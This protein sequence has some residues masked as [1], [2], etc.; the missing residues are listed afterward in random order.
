MYANGTKLRFNNAGGGYLFESLG[1]SGVTISAV[2]GLSLPGAVVIGGNGNGLDFD[3]G[4]N[5]RISFNSNRALEGS[6]DGA[7]LQ[8]GEG[9]TKILSQGREVWYADGVYH[10]KISKTVTCTGSSVTNHEL[11]INTLLGA[12]TA[13]TL[14]YVVSIAGYGSGGSNGCNAKYSV[15]GYSAHNYSGTNYGSFGAGTIQNGYKSSNATSY[16]AQGISYHPCINMGAFIA[17][18]EVWAYSPGGQRY[19]F[20]V[21]NGSSTS[22]G[23]IITVEGVYT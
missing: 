21:S 19:G 12:G 5:Q 14:G 23:A 17:N 6:S 9:Y 18:G 3:D 11:N 22:F 1:G 8:V 7:T 10:F 4:T 20:T 13:G 15:A 2:G 16:N